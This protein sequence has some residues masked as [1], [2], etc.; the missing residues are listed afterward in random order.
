[1]GDC[2]LGIL[3]VSNR[4][5]LTGGDA[6]GRLE[7]DRWPRERYFASEQDRNMHLGRMDGDVECE[8]T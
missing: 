7:S 2:E 4:G 8:T 5:A 6:T 3:T 1:M